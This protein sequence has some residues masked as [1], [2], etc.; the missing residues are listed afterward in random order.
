M[1][2]KKVIGIV[3]Q[4]DDADDNSGGY[5][6]PVNIIKRFLKDV[7]DGKVD[8]M[9]YLPIET[10]KM[11]SLVLREGYYKLPADKSGVLVTKVCANTQAEGVLQKGDIITSISG[12]K[13]ENNS[14]VF[15]SDNT[16]FTFLHY[17]DMHQVGDILELEIMRNDQVK[18]IKLPLRDIAE[19]DLEFDQAP[20][21][22]IY[23][24]YVFVANKANEGCLTKKEHQKS[25]EKD[26]IDNITLMNILPTSHNTGTHQLA[27]MEI[28]K[29]NQDKFSTFKEFYCLVLNGKKPVI[30]LEGSDG[31]V[32]A[33]D[34]TLANK[35]DDKTLEEY[36]IHKPQSFEVEQ[37]AKNMSCHS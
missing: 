12:K 18:N 22:F 27:A 10:Q 15:G 26:K 17:V 33:I 29:V 28:I 5:M 11:E 6:I 24:G 16:R 7:S 32:L 21:Y 9:P 1:V 13:I 2:E 8:G 31:T 36:Q 20:R 3:M 23:A 37:W 34:R 19:E 30:L 35:T 4:F 25:E 14:R